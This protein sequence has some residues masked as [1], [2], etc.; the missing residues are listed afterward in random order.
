MAQAVDLSFEKMT[1]GDIRAIVTYVRSVPAATTSDLPALRTEAAPANPKLG[2]L[3]KI[4]PLGKQVFEGACASCH[5]WTGGSPLD[6]RA[7]LTGSR[8]LNDPTAINVVRMVLSG[9][10]WQ[11]AGS[12]LAMPAFGAAYS[13]KEI[14]AVANYVTGRFGSKVSSLAAEDVRKLRSTE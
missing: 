6:S 10:R 2:M 1:P 3:A 14:A 7:A 4:D 8:A 12:A 5:A 13:D 11:P 9:S